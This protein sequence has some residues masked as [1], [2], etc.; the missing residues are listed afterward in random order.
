MP[1]ISA[2][3][4]RPAGKGKKFFAGADAGRDR[5]RPS[6]GRE[7]LCDG[8]YLCHN[9]DLSGVREYFEQL[10]DMAPDVPDA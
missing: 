3:R 7:G 1:S 2:G 8:K 5:F 6:A 9:R 4:L 10:K